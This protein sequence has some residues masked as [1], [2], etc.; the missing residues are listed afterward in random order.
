M[1]TT[2]YDYLRGRGR[3]G[4]RDGGGDLGK[5]LLMIKHII[6]DMRG[7][8]KIV[9]LSILFVLFWDF[10]VFLN[11]EENVIFVFNDMN[12][13]QNYKIKLNNKINNN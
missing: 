2:G 11:S 13:R 7:L 6:I 1:S 3:E 9:Y 10:D 12:N 5:I 4:G 8:A